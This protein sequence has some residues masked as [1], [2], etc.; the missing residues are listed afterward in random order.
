MKLLFDFDDTIFDTERLK[1]ER[2]F[3]SLQEYGVTKEDFENDY[4][5]WRKTH[6]VYDIREH[7]RHLVTD[8]TLPVN[9]DTVVMNITE[10]LKTYVFPEYLDLIRLYGKKNSFI[11]TQGENDYQRL[12]IKNSGIE[13]EV[14]GVFTVTTSKKEKV[15][16][17][18]ARWGNESILFFDD[19]I[20]NLNFK[21]ETNNLTRI[22]TGNP[23]ALDEKV[24]GTFQELGIE[25]YRREEVVTKIPTLIQPEEKKS[26]I[27]THGGPKMV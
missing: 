10:D 9:V 3:T 26:D 27:P 12:K 24:L 1:E 14:E 21:A 19:K 6:P 11:I 5:S 20:S 8:H 22:F 2:L 18:C 7:L 17:L 16:E 23:M 4:T 15:L 25:T 13:E